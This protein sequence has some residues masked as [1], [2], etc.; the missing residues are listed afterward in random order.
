MTRPHASCV[1]L[2]TLIPILIW[3]WSPAPDVAEVDPLAIH[4]ASIRVNGGGCTM[5]YM[6]GGRTY[7]ITAAHVVGK[8]GSWPQAVTLQGKYMACRVEAKD[9][10]VDLA[11][12]SVDSERCSSVVRV[13]DLTVNKGAFRTI[14]SRGSFKL[15]VAAASER[16]YDVVNRRFYT[17]RVFDVQGGRCR[18]GDSGTGVFRDGKLVGVVTH[19]SGNDSSRTAMSPTAS[20]MRSFIAR[21]KKTISVVSKPLGFADWGKQATADADFAKAKEFE[22]KK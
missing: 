20:D 7:G 14:N 2:A 17:R 22:V 4:Y 19:G 1:T 9:D 18:S 15:K 10:D 21:N 8:V 12:V 6:Q 3:T 11:L 13:A 5:I 16:R